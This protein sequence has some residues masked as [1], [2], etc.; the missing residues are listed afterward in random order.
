M[1][2]IILRGKLTADAEVRLTAD[3]NPTT[4]AR[5]SLAVADR[6]KKDNNG[7]YPVDFIKIVCFNAIA[8]NVQRFTEKGSEV[9]ITGRLHTY[10]YKNKNEQTVYMTEVIT[11]KLEFV[12]N[13]RKSEPEI[14]NIP[15]VDGE[16]P[17][18]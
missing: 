11:E 10:S 2:Q 7:N 6:S 17:F 15:D 16:L 4:I 12:S 1:N 8:D 18:K 14:P 5:F 3:Q 13:C 9:I